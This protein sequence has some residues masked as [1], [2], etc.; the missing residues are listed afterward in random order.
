M[1]LNYKMRIWFHEYILLTRVNGGVTTKLELTDIEIVALES[2]ARYR[3][4]TIFMEIC[5]RQ[6]FFLSRTDDQS[7]NEQSE[8][9]QESKD[10]A[11]SSVSSVAKE[12]FSLTNLPA[13]GSVR[14]LSHS[15]RMQPAGICCVQCASRGQ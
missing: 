14:H 7:S 15:S 4:N 1:H 9:M 6:T 2:Q 10:P 5:Y 12:P 11:R 13:Q 3:T 8:N